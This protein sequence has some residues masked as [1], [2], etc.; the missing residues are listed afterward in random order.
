LIHSASLWFDSILY[1]NH[2][3]AIIA[4]AL[5][6][7]TF[8]LE[9]VAIA[10]GVALAVQGVLGWGES[11][12][13]VAFGIALGDVLLYGLGKL[14]VQWPWLYQHYLRHRHNRLEKFIHERLGFAVILA[15]VIPGMR[16]LTYVYCGYIKAP[17]ISF[18]AW[19]TL[20]V[21]VWTAGLYLLSL[22]I[23]QVIVNTFGIPL[24][25]AVII[26]MLVLAVGAHIYGSRQQ[27]QSL[28]AKSKTN[29]K[30]G[31]SHD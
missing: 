20:S 19:V 24:S 8:L 30:P 25:V 1:G 6:L 12:A 28:V 9:D 7:T 18:A 17:F 10:A 4:L 13:A 23:G 31:L 29:L 3:P 14:A 15:R 2:P 27:K 11:F 5:I 26:P 22:S 21:I 16:L